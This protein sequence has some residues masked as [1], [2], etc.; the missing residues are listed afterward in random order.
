[1]ARDT[2]LDPGIGQKLTT[3]NAPPLSLSPGFK[4]NK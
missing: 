2:C 3:T 1:M 4:E